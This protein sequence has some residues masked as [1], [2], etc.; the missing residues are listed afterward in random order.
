MTPT[1]GQGG[2]DILPPSAVSYGWRL[3]SRPSPQTPGMQV[4]SRQPPLWG[5]LAASPKST[6]RS[7]IDPAEHSEQLN[8]QLN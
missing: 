6:T 7:Q 8:Q 3:S 5:P 1:I 4:L 2:V